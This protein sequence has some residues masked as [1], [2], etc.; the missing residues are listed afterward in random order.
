MS[1]A[2][3]QAEHRDPQDDL[4]VVTLR[5]RTLP[6]QRSPA[7]VRMRRLLKAV[8]RGCGFRNLGQTFEVE[9]EDDQED[10]RSAT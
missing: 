10:G 1:N 9:Q 3:D 6:G 2:N 8:L 4:G 5:L 7:S